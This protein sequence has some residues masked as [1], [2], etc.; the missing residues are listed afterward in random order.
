MMKKNVSL[1]ALLVA[2]LFSQQLPASA[3]Q[4][5]PPEKK[6]PVKFKKV[7]IAAESFESVGVFDVNNDGH[8]DI[9]SGTIW[10]EGPGFWQ[11][12]FMLDE[13]RF[14]QYYDDFSTIPIDVNGDGYK[15]F[16]TGGWFGKSLRWIENPGKEKKLWIEHP[17]TDCGNVETTYSWDVDGDGMAEIVPNTP[18]YPLIC[19]RLDTIKHSFDKYTITDK[20]DHGLGFGDVNG[21]GRGDFVISKGWI[22]AP[23]DRWKG[24]WIM[25]AEFDLETASV[26][27]I[28]ADVNGDGLTD[29]VA[30]VAHGYGLNWYE[31]QI[32]KKT[33]NRTWIKH[34]I[35]PFNSQ[36]HSLMWT[37]IDGDGKSEVVTGKRYRAHDGG[38]PGEQDD[39][40]LYYF[41]WNG[42]S[43]TKNVI[44]YGPYGTGKGAGLYFS[45]ED[46]RGTGRKDIIVA[47]KD[48]LC[49][50]YNEGN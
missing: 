15:D 23:A 38:D 22:E 17:I 32:D 24:K 25:H 11:R 35:D 30:G 7:P 4:A 26:P 21:D 6:G 42:E 13:K 28:V 33:K 29:L 36:Y 40:G 46:L 9:V 37:D 2:A 44:S 3:Q 50:F 41:K 8:P 43:F 49:I 34:A 14:E 47:G 27:V 48:G 12:H 16:V 39:L 18:G 19:L 31:Q 5:K 1:S 10:Y 20:Q 45:V